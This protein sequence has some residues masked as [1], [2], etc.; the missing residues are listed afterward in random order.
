MQ[1]ER[2]Y[3]CENIANKGW[4]AFYIKLSVLKLLIENNN[5]YLLFIHVYFMILVAIVYN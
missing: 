2:I 5:I 1:L 4:V 3:I